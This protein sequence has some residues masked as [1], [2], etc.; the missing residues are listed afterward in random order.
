MFRPFVG[1]YYACANTTVR[2]RVFNESGVPERQV[3]RRSAGDCPTYSTIGQFRHSCCIDQSQHSIQ[4]RTNQIASQIMNY[5]LAATLN[6]LTFLNENHRELF[7]RSSTYSITNKYFPISV[8]ELKSGF[9][10]ENREESVIFA[11]AAGDTEM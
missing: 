3:A 6:Y 5:F 7:H 1:P 9:I 11:P 8:F 10:D 4:N 2:G